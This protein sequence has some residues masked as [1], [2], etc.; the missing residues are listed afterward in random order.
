M[1]KQEMCIY[2]NNNLILLMVMGIVCLSSQAQ[3]AIAAASDS[4]YW[5]QIED[6]KYTMPAALCGEIFDG[7]EFIVQAQSDDHFI[8]IRFGRIDYSVENDFDF[9]G[10]LRMD[11]SFPAMDNSPFYLLNRSMETTI[12][13]DKDGIEGSAAMR[14]ENETGKEMY[15]EGFEISFNLGCRNE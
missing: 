12:S 7:E 8:K 15:P 3:L 5:I 14:P 4:D 13:G 10:P 2:K 6:N 11:V 1:N 9:T